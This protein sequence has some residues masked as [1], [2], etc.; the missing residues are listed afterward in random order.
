MIGLLFLICLM[1]T[2]KKIKKNVKRLL[3]FHCGIGLSEFLT[4]KEYSLGWEHNCLATRANL[5][6]CH[7]EAFKPTICSHS[8]TLL[9]AQQGQA[10]PDLDLLKL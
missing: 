7:F 4:R 9:Q 5:L 2:L 3:I 1:L 6:K 8:H 10:R